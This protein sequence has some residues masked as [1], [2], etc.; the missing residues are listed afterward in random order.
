MDKPPIIQNKSGSIA[1]LLVT[2]LDIAW[3]VAKSQDEWWWQQWADTQRLV[4][5]NL[6]AVHS[7]Q[8][9]VASGSDPRWPVIGGW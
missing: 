6:H 5:R 7:P 8:C 4:N 9:T 1:H 2:L 3:L